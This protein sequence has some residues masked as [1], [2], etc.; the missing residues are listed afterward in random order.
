MMRSEDRPLLKT[1]G[2]VSFFISFF[3]WT[4]FNL[5]GFDTQP[6][7]VITAFLFLVFS[8]RINF[9]SSS[10]ILFVTSII[11]G[12]FVCFLLSYGHISF[13][14]IRGFFN[15]LCLLLMCVFFYNFLRLFGP[16]I[17]LILF[18]NVLWILL[19][20]IEFYVSDISS[21]FSTIRSSSERGVTSFAPEPYYF[22]IM[23]LFFNFI[24]III[25]RREAISQDTVRLNKIIIFLSVL[26]IFGIVFLSQSMS[27][28]L[29]LPIFFIIFFL[30]SIDR[31][32]PLSVVASLL[33]A[34]LLIAGGI[35]SLAQFFIRGRADEIIGSIISGNLFNLIHTDGSANQ[36]LEGIISPIVLFLKNFPVPAGFENFFIQ[37]SFLLQYSDFFWFPTVNNTILSWVGAMVYELGIFGLLGCALFII[38]QTKSNVFEILFSCGFVFILFFAIPVSFPLVAFIFALRRINLSG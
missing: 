20:T 29:L 15:Y 14:V 6:W 13:S 32:T 38:S 35:L 36:R 26:N 11:S 27:V 22:G 3:P 34:I 19:G 1:L 21:I 28:I 16:A 18:A 12:L 25:L 2:S 31:Y 33:I 17:R 9:I 4:S 8:D 10:F 5:N 30:Q 37:K 24:Y 23:L 7:F